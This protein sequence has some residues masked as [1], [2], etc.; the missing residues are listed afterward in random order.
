VGTLI[1]IEFLDLRMLTSS[2]TGDSVMTYLMK[3]VV[4]LGLV[5]LGGL[6]AVHGNVTGETWEMSAGVLLAVIGVVLLAMKIVRR[7]RESIAR[8]AI[9]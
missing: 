6:T 7:N 8:P 3:K 1:S 4:G 5:L 9:D 2:R